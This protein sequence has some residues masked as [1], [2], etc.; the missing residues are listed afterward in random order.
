MG[1]DDE[2]KQSERKSS[3]SINVDDW[4]K[5][6]RTNGVYFFSPVQMIN[7]IGQIETPFFHAPEIYTI[8]VLCFVWLASF[9]E[10]CASCFFVPPPKPDSHVV[11]AILIYSRICKNILI[12]NRQRFFLFE[13]SFNS[14]KSIRSVFYSKW[15]CSFLFPSEQRFPFDGFCINGTRKKRTHKVP[16]ECNIFRCIDRLSVS[17]TNWGSDSKWC[18]WWCICV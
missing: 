7:N 6:S 13:F 4:K 14:F 15:F 12:P 1:S 11:T 17:K 10:T 2:K 8:Y 5:T 3:S 18:W 9:M 16:F